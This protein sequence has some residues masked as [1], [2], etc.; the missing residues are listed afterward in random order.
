MEIKVLYIKN[1]HVLGS[2]IDFKLSN[3]LT[4]AVYYKGFLKEYH[5][6]FKKRFIYLL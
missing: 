4:V 2:V 5:Q 6:L 3:T 1:V